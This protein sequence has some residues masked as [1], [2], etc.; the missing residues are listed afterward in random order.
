M[1]SRTLP[2]QQLTRPSLGTRA[3]TPPPALRELQAL[4]RPLRSLTRHTVVASPATRVGGPSC[5][6]TLP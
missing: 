2:P 3:G 4:Q 5:D 1:N 6:P